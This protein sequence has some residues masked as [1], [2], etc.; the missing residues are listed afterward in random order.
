MRAKTSAIALLPRE[1]KGLAISTES[2][3]ARC[4][5]RC[6]NPHRRARTRSCR[7]IRR[8]NLYTV[9]CLCSDSWLDNPSP[10]HSSL[11]DPR[12]VGHTIEVDERKEPIGVS[13]FYLYR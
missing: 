2:Y 9:F 5:L 10:T 7:N 12:S 4:T 6:T 13:L 8:H 1:L 11:I 3:L